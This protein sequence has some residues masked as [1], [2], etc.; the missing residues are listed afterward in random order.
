MRGHSACFSFL[1]WEACESLGVG[2]SEHCMS[3]TPF[4]YISSFFIIL[5]CLVGDR[6]CLYFLIMPIFRVTVKRRKN[7]NGVLLEPGMSVDVVTQSFS[8][9]VSTNG[10]QAVANAFMRIYGIDIKRACALNCGDLD[11]E[12]VG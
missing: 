6:G 9:P 10:G 11:V 4:L 2:T 12:R 7:A 3:P 8:N 5:T 1:T